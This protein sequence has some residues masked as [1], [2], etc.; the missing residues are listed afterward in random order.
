MLSNCFI[1][2][3]EIDVK[4]DAETNVRTLTILVISK[5]ENFSATAALIIR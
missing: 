4:Q 2:T 5:A 3:A 1:K